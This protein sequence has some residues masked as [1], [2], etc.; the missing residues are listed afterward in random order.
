MLCGIIIGLCFGIVFK[1]YRALELVKKCTLKPSMNGMCKLSNLV[2]IEIVS[3][4]KTNVTF[5]Y[6]LQLPWKSLVFRQTIQY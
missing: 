6:V 4:I 2:G 5:V 3:E 1:N